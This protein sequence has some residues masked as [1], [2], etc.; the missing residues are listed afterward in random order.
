MQKVTAFLEQ[1][2]QWVAIALGALFVLY[3]TYSYVIT[4]PAEVTIGSDS[5]GPSEID[6]H[7]AETVVAKLQSAMTN[8]AKIKMEVPQYVQAFQDTMT[9]KNAKPVELPRL[10]DPALTLDVPLPPQPQGP[11]GTIVQNIPPGGTPPAPLTPGAKIT[12]LPV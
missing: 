7:T 12:Q 5:Y 10:I 2:V 3:M 8:N 9:W 1:H 6:P 4:P 11:N